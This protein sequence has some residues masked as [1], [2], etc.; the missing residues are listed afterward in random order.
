M[1]RHDVSERWRPVVGELDDAIEHLN[2]ALAALRDLRRRVEEL[3]RDVDG[4]D[5]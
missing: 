5:R 2:G 3:S 1:E 4:G